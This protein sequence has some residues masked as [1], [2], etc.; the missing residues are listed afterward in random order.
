MKSLFPFIL[1][2][3]IIGCANDDK[4]DK[5]LDTITLIKDNGSILI[6]KDTA[7]TKINLDSSSIV[8]ENS[9]PDDTTITKIKSY[10]NTTNFDENVAA[11]EVFHGVIAKRHYQLPKPL[12]DNG[13]TYKTILKRLKEED[14]DDPLGGTSEWSQWLYK[15]T[16]RP[17]GWSKDG[18]FAFIINGIGEVEYVTLAIINSKINKIIYEIN[19]GDVSLNQI[20]HYNYGTIEKVL[21]DYKIIQQYDFQL[22]IKSLSQIKLKDHPEEKN[23]FAVLKGT[24][25]ILQNPFESNAVTVDYYFWHDAGRGE[26]GTEFDV[27]GIQIN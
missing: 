20:W 7:I 6:N 18:K 27:T 1:L 12:D 23:G 13:I 8:Q 10:F 11:D 3:L 9:N 19:G 15:E 24:I 25:G 17:I 4:I 16:F 22:E 2:S 14:W 26:G 21:T 5:T